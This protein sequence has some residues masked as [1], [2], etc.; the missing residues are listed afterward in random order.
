MIPD[1][2]IK[3]VVSASI[4]L[5]G[6]L[7]FD[8]HAS[9]ASSD[10]YFFAGKTINL[11]VS[12]DTGGGYDSYSRLLA[13]H[14]AAHI[15]GAPVIVVQNMPG[16]GGLRAAQYLWDVAPKDGTVIGNVR[17]S[18]MLDSILGIRGNAID[19]RKFLWIGNMASDT[20]VCSFSRT[21]G[22]R[23]F[24]DLRKKEVIV[25]ASGKGAQNF[26]FSNAIDKVLG[27]K[28]KIVLGYKGAADRV[29]AVQRGELQGNCGINAST[30]TSS[31]PQLLQSGELI[32]VIQ[33]GLKPYPAL[34][35]VPM[36]QSFAKTDEQRRILD[37]IFAQ[38]EIART[39]A[40]PPGTP[41]HRLALLRT[42][43]LDT[44]NDPALKADAKKTKLDLN[45][46]TGEQVNAIFE[47]MANVSDDLKK[48][49]R[50]AIGG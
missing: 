22:I 43:F 20:D 8:P 19:P 35:K 17:A 25:G 33:S 14:I 29:L 27:A 30:L 18:N 26:S 48:K 41:A 40:L 16:G 21:S 4:I 28:M 36:T 49:V 6:A 1:T 45:L 32:P 50:T 11:T 34:P 15:P 44:M 39:Y 2:L 12:S 10:P 37:T 3:P 13:R 38:M 47:K 23:T 31:Y 5:A 9:A 7:A 42:A 46:E 24:D